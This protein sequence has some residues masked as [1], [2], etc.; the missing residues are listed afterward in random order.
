MNVPV[1]SQN[2]EHRSGGYADAQ[3][4]GLDGYQGTG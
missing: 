1:Y 4:G 2:S 3:K